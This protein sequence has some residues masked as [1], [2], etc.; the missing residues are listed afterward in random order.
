MRLVRTTVILLA[1]LAAGAGCSPSDPDAPRD[2]CADTIAALISEQHRWYDYDMTH[3]RG[4]VDLTWMVTPPNPPATA[5]QIDAAEQRLGKRLDRQLR[6]WLEHANGWE[7]AFGTTTLYSTD[8]LTPDSP[9]RDIFL[10]G[11][12]ETDTQIDEFGVDSFDDL[13]IIGTND[14]Q[15]RF[16]L[17]TGCADDSDCDSAPVWAFDGDIE[18]FAGLRD[19]LTKRVE[20]LKAAKR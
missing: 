12:G 14:N 18:K 10:E 19:F 11:I 3:G 8:Q 6:N 4:N 9:E 2:W 16:I 13:T 20:G 15:S 17:T 1:A 7:F 5:E